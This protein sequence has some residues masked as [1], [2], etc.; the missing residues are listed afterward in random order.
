MWQGQASGGYGKTNVEVI[1][2]ERERG[3][4]AEKAF[5]DIFELGLKHYEEF[6]GDTLWVLGAGIPGA[7][8]K[9]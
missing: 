9:E 7:G 1:S 3:I 5:R 6:L 8:M 2:T 4:M